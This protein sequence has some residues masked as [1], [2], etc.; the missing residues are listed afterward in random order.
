[1]KSFKPGRGP[2][3]MGGVVSILIGLFGVI[4]TF[5]VLSMGG[6]FFALFGVIFI[7]IAIVQAV[8]HFKNATNKNRYSTFDIVDDNEEPDPLNLKYGNRKDVEPWDMVPENYNNTDADVFCPY[9]GAPVDSDFKYCR[10][11]G[12]QQPE[13]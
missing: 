2:S 1:M 9:C 6:G 7:A 8:Y 10:K 4:W 3:M 12:R 11:C 13:E 5:S